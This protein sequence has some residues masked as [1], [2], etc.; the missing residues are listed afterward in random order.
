MRYIDHDI[1]KKRES[2]RSVVEKVGLMDNLAPIV[3][4]GE[5]EVLRKIQRGKASEYLVT[6]RSM[7]A[8]HTQ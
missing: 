8:P 3:E 2:R 7:E 4:D 6:I 1:Y 5:W